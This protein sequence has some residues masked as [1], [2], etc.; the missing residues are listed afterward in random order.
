M[1]R[2]LAAYLPL[3]GIILLASPA[4]ARACEEWR[5]APAMSAGVLPDA[6]DE[7]PVLWCERSDDP[8][9]APGS[10]GTEAP[11]LSRRATL[12]PPVPHLPGPM[13]RAAVFPTAPAVG[14]Q[15]GIR[16]RVPRPPRR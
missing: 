14:P 1:A 2:R 7:A 16:H 13:I 6:L 8:R 10:R 4:E 11:E 12:R 3:L 5:Q 9:C 15:T